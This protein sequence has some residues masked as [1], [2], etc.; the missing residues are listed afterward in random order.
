MEA[1]NG[2]GLFSTIIPINTNTCDEANPDPCKRPCNWNLDF[3][4]KSLHPG[5]ALFLMGD[6]SVQFF[7][8]SIDHW[9]YQ[10]LGTIDDGH[11]A[12]LP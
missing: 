8:Q 3:G 6:N 4:Y 5:G 2:N 7:P 12:T 10:W 1:N 11:A 9:T